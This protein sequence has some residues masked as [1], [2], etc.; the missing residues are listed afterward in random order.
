[1]A[2]CMWNI[3]E[4]QCFASQNTGH[5]SAPLSNREGTGH[6]AHGKGHTARGKDIETEI[7]RK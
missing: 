2:K 4:T 3:V 6:G 7:Y 1:M 5:A